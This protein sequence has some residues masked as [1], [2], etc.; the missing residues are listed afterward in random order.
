MRAMQT[1]VLDLS[2]QA[3]EAIFSGF[4]KKQRN[5]IRRAYKLDVKVEMIELERFDLFMKLS[6]E[7]KERVGL[8]RID[9]SFY[10]LILSHYQK[11]G[12]AVCIAASYNDEIISSMIL[13]SNSNYT[14][15]WV[16]GRKSDMPNNLYQNEMLLWESIRWGIAYGSK[17]I[18]FCGLDE[19]ELPHLARMKLSFSDDKRPF[20]K[21]VKKDFAYKT[22]SR[23][24]KVS[25]NRVKG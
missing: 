23:L 3:E 25:H 9:P 7:L 8:K 18:D 15:A 19:E 10:R 11:L 14:I 22:M 12:K 2:H 4:E 5:K 17:Y 24:Q 16:A 1:L 21:I 20:F 13:L 6:N